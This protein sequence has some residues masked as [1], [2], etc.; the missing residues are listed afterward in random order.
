M[1]FPTKVQLI[2]RKKSRQWYI[3]VPSAVAQAVD[4]GKG[5]RVEWIVEDKANLVLHRPEAPPWPV[6]VKKTRRP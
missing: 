3:N 4:L 5:E 6:R 1:G 2:Q